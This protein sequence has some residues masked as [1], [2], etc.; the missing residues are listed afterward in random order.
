MYKKYFYLTSWVNKKYLNRKITWMALDN[1][2]VKICELEDE[3]IKTIP[4]ETQG[5]K[6]D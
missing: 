6:K 5:D 4:N 3:A 2:Q 1:A